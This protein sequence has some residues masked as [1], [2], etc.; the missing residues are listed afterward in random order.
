[1]IADLVRA[2]QVVVEHRAA[3]W[4]AAVVGAAVRLGHSVRR[5]LALRR[6]GR[7]R[8]PRAAPPEDVAAKLP[9]FFRAEV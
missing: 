6:C 3:G 5:R 8:G 1:M 7:R 4:G 9:S 2:G